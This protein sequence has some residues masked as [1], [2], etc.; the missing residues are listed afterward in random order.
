L[1]VT[2]RNAV[3]HSW[4]SDLAKDATYGKWWSNLHALG[5]KLKKA[6][7]SGKMTREEVKTKL[8]AAANVSDDAGILY[9]MPWLARQAK[10]NTEADVSYLAVLSVTSGQAIPVVA[11]A[12]SRFRIVGQVES[13]TNVTFGITTLARNGGFA[14]KYSA[15]RSIESSEPDGSFDIEI[16][17][18]EFQPVVVNTELVESP[19]HQELADWWC[20]TTGKDVKFAI[21]RV[22]LLPAMSL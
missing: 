17:L 8:S 20:I 3:T 12:G 16:P 4:R 18:L 21:R 5:V 11:D 7:T 1:E 13:S 15:V 22:E 10:S 6:V 19:S 9:A 2:G 14:G